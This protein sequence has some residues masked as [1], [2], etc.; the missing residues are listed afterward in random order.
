MQVTKIIVY[1]FAN[2]VKKSNLQLQAELTATKTK[3]AFVL[4]SQQGRLLVA[5]LW[6]SSTA[7]QIKAN[8]KEFYAKIASAAKDF[9]IHV[10]Y[11]FDPRYIYHNFVKEFGK[12][13]K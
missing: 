12:K 2:F 1:N 4:Y 10:I 3:E 11:I 13:C 5:Q 9:Q 6:H 8:L 7:E